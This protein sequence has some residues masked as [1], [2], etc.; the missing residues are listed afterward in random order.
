MNINDN[1]AGIVIDK[2]K[3]ILYVRRPW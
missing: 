1:I 2:N 3:M